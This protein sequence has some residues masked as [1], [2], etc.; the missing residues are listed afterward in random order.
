MTT[1]QTWLSPSG[2][3][4]IVIAV[5]ATPAACTPSRS[6]GPPATVTLAVTLTEPHNPRGVPP[7]PVRGPALAAVLAAFISSG[8]PILLS[9]ATMFVR[10]WLPFTRS[11]SSEK[12]LLAYRITTVVYGLVA[13]LGAWMVSTL[14]NV[15][16]LDMLL[17]GFAMVVPPAVAIAYTLYW[18]RTTELGAFSGMLVG[19][20][21]GLMWFVL[22]K[23]ALAVES[24]A[25]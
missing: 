10:D 19:Y 5:F 7:A 22:I 4:A 1:K 20:G 8:G 24:A 13:A 2:A 21:S 23:W 6:A 3:V 15:S 17:F 9:S 16:I 18:K 12:K 11:Y 25:P 14:P